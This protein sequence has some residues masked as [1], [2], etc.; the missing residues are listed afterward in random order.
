[1]ASVHYIFF[2]LVAYNIAC[3]IDKMTTCRHI[4]SSLYFALFS[5]TMA[6]RILFS[7]TQKKKIHRLIS[8]CCSVASLFIKQASDWVC[9]FDMNFKLIKRFKMQVGVSNIIERQGMYFFFF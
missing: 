2:G 9:Y 3:I 8:F 6:Y 5:T 4:S 7:V 1:M